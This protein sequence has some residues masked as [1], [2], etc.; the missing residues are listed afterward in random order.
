MLSERTSSDICKKIEIPDVNE[1]LVPKSVVKKAISNH[2]YKEMKA[3]IESMKK[4]EPIRNEDFRGTQDYY[5]KRPHV[6]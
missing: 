6:F 2:H 5:R 1:T 3:E 4:L